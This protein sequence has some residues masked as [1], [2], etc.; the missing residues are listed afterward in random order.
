MF[1]FL[2]YGFGSVFGGLITT[3]V[4]SGILLFLSFRNSNG[5]V[6]PLALIGAFILF[7]L[8]FF[9][10]TSMYCAINYK[11]V[12]LKF[13]TALNLQIGDQI[14]GQEL[15]EIVRNAITENPILLFFI[16][17]ADL[18]DFDWSR[19]IH[20]LRDVVSREFNWYIFRRI[21]WSLLFIILFGGMMFIPY[22]G[23]GRNKRKRI[24]STFS[25]DEYFEDTYSDDYDYNDY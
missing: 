16:D 15:K 7:C 4:I 22:R 5:A 8:L 23:S 6:S 20:S 19:P 2:S 21:L 24:Y 1:E 25:E 13:I 10:M 9:Q 3:L 11:G 17:Y 14:N 12:A 18:E